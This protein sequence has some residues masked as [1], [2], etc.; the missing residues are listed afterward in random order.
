MLFIAALITS[1]QPVPEKPHVLF[2]ISDDLRPTL[3]AYGS[4]ALTPHVDGLAQEGL[5]FTRAYTQF[6]WCSPSRQS[7]M[8]GRR[9]DNTK[10]WTFTVSFRDALPHA[11]SLSQHFRQSG[12]HAA[13]VGKIFH[14]RNCVRG[15]PGCCAANTT[16][17]ECVQQPTDA[18]FGGGELSWDERPVDFGRVGCPKDVQ[19]CESPAPDEQYCDYKVADAAIARLQA[20]AASHTDKPLF[21]AVGFRDNHLKWAAPARFRAALD[22]ANLTITRHAETPSFDAA[23]GGVPRQAW[24]WPVWVGSTYKLSAAVRLSD[25]DLHEA[26]PD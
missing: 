4:A 7:F 17:H 11:V 20:H 21:L 1:A 22:P 13:S 14:G 16:F 24:Q 19:W 25:A 5:T 9:P 18:D 26:L 2:I 6:P 15:D 8:T 23:S 10:S 3:G 12:W